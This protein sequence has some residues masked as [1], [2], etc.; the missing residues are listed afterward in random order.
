MPDLGTFQVLVG[1]HGVVPILEEHFVGFLSE[2]LT[3]TILT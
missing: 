2:R 1:T 3:Q